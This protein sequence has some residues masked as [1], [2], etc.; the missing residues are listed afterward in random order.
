MLQ[1]SSLDRG[2]FNLP[3]QVMQ[4]DTTYYWKSSWQD[5]PYSATALM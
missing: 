4:E 5:R 2:Q 3:G 1:L